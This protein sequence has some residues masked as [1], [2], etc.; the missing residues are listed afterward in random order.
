MLSASNL[1]PN[2]FCED[3][4]RLLPPLWLLSE[5]RF[6]RDRYIYS[7]S[8]RNDLES[9]WCTAAY[10]DD[11]SWRPRSWRPW[12]FVAFL[13]QRSAAIAALQIPAD[14]DSDGYTDADTCSVTEPIA[15]CY[16]DPGA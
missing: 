5:Q 9:N 13:S 1:R 16:P 4:S 3:Y 2:S 10:S 12:K 6:V 15:G 8:G 7:E 14:A 11:D